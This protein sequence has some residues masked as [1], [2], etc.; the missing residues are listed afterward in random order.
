MRLCPHPNPLPPSGRGDTLLVVG[1]TSATGWGVVVWV[2]PHPM[3]ARLP[4]PW[5]PLLIS[6]SG[7]GGEWL[8]GEGIRCCGR[9]YFCD[10]G[11]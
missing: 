3:A 7:G 5:D 2:E 1:G 11:W 10:G 6:P 9:G 8:A 4:S